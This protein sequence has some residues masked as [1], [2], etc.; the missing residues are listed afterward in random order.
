MQGKYSLPK[1]TGL[2]W[3][4]KTWT[5][6]WHKLQ[7]PWN[8]AYVE[9]LASY[10]LHKLRENDVS[11][12]FNLF[13]GAYCAKADVYRF[14]INDDFGSYRNTNWFW[15]GVENDLYNLSIFNSE[16]PEAEIPEEIRAELLTKPEFDEESEEEMEEDEELDEIEVGD[17]EVAELESLHSDALESASE[18]EE[19]EEEEE[20]DNYSIYADI[21]NFPVMTIFSENNIDTM[22]SL[23]NLDTSSEE[24]G[25]EEWEAKWSAW[26]FQVI[27]A[28]CVMQKILG[29]THNDLHTNNIVWSPT[30]IEF[31]YYKGA[32]GTV[33]K[34]PTYGKI[35]RL[36]DF[37]R[38][39]YTINGKMFVS[40]DFRN[41]ND[42]AGQYSF[43]PLFSNPKEVVAPNPSF[44]LSRLAVSLFE[45]LF[46][47]KPE[48]TESKKIL[49]EEDGLVVRE[50]KSDLYNIL[51]TWMVDEEDKNI[52]MEPDGSERFPD[53]DLYKHIAAYCK[54]AYPDE[55]IY[56]KPFSNFIVPSNQVPEGAKQ[57]PLFA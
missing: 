6:A 51:W 23:L 56:K 7:D 53:F 25:T 31:L 40:D 24:P 32:N 30:D 35:F 21:Y 46:P 3:H 4:S 42:A 43:S 16:D 34:V 57:Y 36:I 44:D 33:W 48:D 1:E 27:A 5:T 37:G 20:E 29:M 45:A 9:T 8:Q 2:P 54:N 19:D 39:I 47:Q 13:Y 11:P 28:L 26:I 15:K 14:N 50:T 52:L 22:D 10:A 55:Q 41:G 49:S 17:V 18:E 38:S 12:H